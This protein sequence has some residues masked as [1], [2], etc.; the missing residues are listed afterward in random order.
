MSDTKQTNA[1]PRGRGGNRRLSPSQ[2]DA[3]VKAAYILDAVRR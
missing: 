3:V 2:L 1:P